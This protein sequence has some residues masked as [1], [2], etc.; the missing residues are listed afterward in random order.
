MQSKL[1][2]VYTRDARNGDLC[3]V[4][5]V[6]ALVSIMRTSITS[7][8]GLARARLDTDSSRLKRGDLEFGNSYCLCRMA[9]LPATC[10]HMQ[11]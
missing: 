11:L 5:V 7:G 10:L 2:V 3:Q 8:S 9:I 4:M 6:G 1:A